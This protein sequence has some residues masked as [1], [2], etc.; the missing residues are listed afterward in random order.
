MG[1]LFAVP[2]DCWHLLCPNFNYILP[3][4]IF[5]PHLTSQTQ[6]STFYILHLMTYITY[7]RLDV[8]HPRY[9]FKVPLN[10]K[11]CSLSSRLFTKFKSS[12]VI[13]C[14]IPFSS[15]WPLG[16]FDLVVTMSV[17][18]SVCVFVPFHVVY[19]EAYFTPTSQSQMSKSFRDSGSLRKST[20]KKWS[21]NW[22]FLLGSGLKSPC[23]KKF[24]FLLILPYKTWWK[25]RFLMDK[26]PLVEGISLILTNL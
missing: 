14:Q 12:Y 26:R 5:T 8:L 13:H 9:S 3:S 1:I 18:V 24:V 25:Q 4:K 20:G 10:V 6:F 11:I 21:Q 16:R 22:T 2:E 23:K 7:F 15:N 17:S 19:F